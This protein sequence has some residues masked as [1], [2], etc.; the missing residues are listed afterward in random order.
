M[1][2]YFAP[3]AMAFLSI[4]VILVNERRADLLLLS[5]IVLYVVTISGFRYFSDIDYVPYLD[6]YRE[7]PRLTE[8]RLD[9]LRVLYG[10]P[11]YLFFTS[12]VKSAHG[13]FFVVTFLASLCPLW[14]MTTFALAVSPSPKTSTS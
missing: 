7:T 3:I 11:G 6:L 9:D 1:Y 5:L 4:L 10:E 12:L 8:W 13:H 14:L 2:V